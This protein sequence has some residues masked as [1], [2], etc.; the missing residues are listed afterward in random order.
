MNNKKQSWRVKILT[1]TYLKKIKYDYQ[2]QKLFR[3]EELVEKENSICYNLFYQLS[4]ASLKRK[5]TNSG[6]TWCRPF[7]Y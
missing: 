4:A 7:K 6:N 1:Y 2:D 3:K 5:N